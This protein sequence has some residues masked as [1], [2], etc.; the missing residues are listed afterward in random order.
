M[1]T[2]SDSPRKKHLREEYMARINRVMDHIESH[3]DGELS[4]EVLARVAGFSPFHFHRLFNAIV[5]EPL[6]RFIQRV[7][8]EKAATQLASNPK[9]PITSIAYDCG[10]SGPAPFARAFREAF[11]TS[12]SAYRR[13]MHD[14]DSK[15]RKPKSKTGKSNSKAGKDRASEGPYTGSQK[16][17][18][19]RRT[20]MKTK[21]PLSVTVREMP[22]YSVAY[23]RHMGP[24]KGDSALFENLFGR[25]C[26]WAGAR[27][28]MSAPGVKMLAL[29][30]DNP[31]IT[32]PEKLRVSVCI[33]VPAGTLGEG[34]VNTMTV[35]G[36]KFAVGRFEIARPEEYEAAWNALCGG[37]LPESGFQPDDRPPYELYEVDGWDEKSAKHTVDICMPV[38]PL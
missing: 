20:S 12:A 14:A 18:R 17:Q 15:T 30:H 23:I 3:I 4:L 31:D 19:T 8:L 37:W 34:E 27:G 1:D 25:L 38:R 7:R 13:A 6:F 22:A 32:E 26:A 29:Y 16:L 24:Y 35:P 21:Q 9:K 10:F 11:G 33:T 5:G 28:H 36:G 2:T